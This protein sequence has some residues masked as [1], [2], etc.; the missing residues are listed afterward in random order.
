MAIDFDKKVACPSYEQLKTIDNLEM[1]SVFFIVRN[2]RRTRNETTS[3]FYI[4]QAITT[5]QATSSLYFLSGLVKQEKQES[6]REIWLG[7]EDVRHA[8]GG[9]RVRKDPDTRCNLLRVTSQN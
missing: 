5:Q 2:S 3:F 7:R 9:F 8:A 1:L 6:A 4:W